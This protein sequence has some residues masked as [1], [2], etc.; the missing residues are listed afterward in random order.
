MVPKVFEP[1]KI[2]CNVFLPPVMDT[3]NQI[4]KSAGKLERLICQV[5]LCLGKSL[6]FGLLCV[7]FVVFVKFCVCPSSLLVFRVGCGM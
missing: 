6:S 3:W 2:D 5:E 1:L 4:Q 7:S